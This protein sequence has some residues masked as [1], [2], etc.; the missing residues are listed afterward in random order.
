MDKSLFIHTTEQDTFEE[1]MKSISFDKEVEYA[2][3]NYDEKIKKPDLLGKTV[4]VTTIQFKEIHKIVKDICSILY[5]DEPEVFVYEDFFYS[6]DSKGLSKPWIEISAKT[7]TDFSLVELKF[8]FGKVLCNIALEHTKYF[9]IGD[10]L[11]N[12]LKN[13]NLFTGSTTLSESWKLSMYRWSRAT[14][15]TSDNFGYLISKDIKACTNAM[16]KFVLNNKFLAENLNVQ[17]Y[18]KQSEEINKLD[19]NVYNYTKLD[20][21]IPYGPFRIKNLLAYAASNRGIEALK[22]LKEI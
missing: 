10:Q 5:I 18:I 14:N 15:Y 22:K 11:I 6:I 1:M 3:I 20:E 7:I 9:T 8:L 17:E 13:N 12:I 4:K 16:I 19:D 2:Y 21:A